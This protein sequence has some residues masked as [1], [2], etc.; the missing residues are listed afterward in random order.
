MAAPR[1]KEWTGVFIAL[2]ILGYGLMFIDN[3]KSDAELLNY[4]TD[5]ILALGL[6]AISTATWISWSYLRRYD[7]P[8]HD[9]D[10]EED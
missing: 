3:V 6:S 9:A 8:G 2:T 5:I 1:G 10:D 4:F 7:S